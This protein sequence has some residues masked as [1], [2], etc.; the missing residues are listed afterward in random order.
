MAKNLQ[1]QSDVVVLEPRVVRDHLNSGG[2]TDQATV[3]ALYISLIASVYIGFAVADGRP[4]VIFVESAVVAVFVLIAASGVTGSSWLLVAGYA[5]YGLKD[6]WQ[7]RRHYV[8][9]TRWW[10]LFCAAVDWLVAIILVV[11]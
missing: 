11:E 4:R 9:N 10:P 5:G 1:R 8:A 2:A 6:F 7:E 3:H